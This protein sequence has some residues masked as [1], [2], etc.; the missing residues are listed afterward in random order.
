VE[1]RDRAPLVSIIEG[2]EN[3][4]DEEKEC[5]V[6][7]LDIYLNDPSQDDYLFIGATNE[8]DIPIGYVCYG[9]AALACGVY[10]IYWILVGPEDRGKGVGKRLVQDTESLLRKEGARM[11]VVETSGLPSYESVRSFYLS[12]GFKQEARIRGFFKPDDDK[13]IYIKN[14]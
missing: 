6:E 9:K 14:L 11:L 8:R 3:L 7:L 10:D 5:A 4:T 13:I 2:C 12:N 1:K